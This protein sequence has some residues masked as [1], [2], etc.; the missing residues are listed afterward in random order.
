VRRTVGSMITPMSVLAGGLRGGIAGPED[1]QRRAWRT[2]SKN[3]TKPTPTAPAVTGPDRKRTPRAT[4]AG[5]AV[6][7][8]TR[9]AGGGPHPTARDAR[10]TGGRTPVRD[11]AGAD[12][13][14]P[15]R[16]APT[17]IPASNPPPAD[18]GVPSA[19]GETRR[20]DPAEA[21]TGPIPRVE[22]PVSDPGYDHHLD[23][24]IDPS[25]PADVFDDRVRDRHVPRDFDPDDPDWPRARSEARAA[26]S[27]AAPVAA[28]PARRS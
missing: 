2:L 26:A 14:R 19:R 5:T 23:R 12:P 17:P 11:S 24:P 10:T 16:R 25:D 21:L 18:S 7:T 13:V 22:I 6:D 28:G 9:K 8:S 3:A 1:A 4:R 15:R 27:E 20:P